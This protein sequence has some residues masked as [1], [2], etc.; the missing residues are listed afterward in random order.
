M[1]HGALHGCWRYT[2]HT[3][4]HDI[5]LTIHKFSLSVSERVSGEDKR[6]REREG[7]LHNSD[8]F[9]DQVGGR[10]RRYQVRN[11]EFSRGFR[12]SLSLSLSL[13]LDLRLS[14]NDI[15]ME[16]LI[17]CYGCKTAAARRI[18][19]EPLFL[20]RGSPPNSLAHYTQ[21]LLL[22]CLFVVLSYTSSLFVEGLLVKAI[23]CVCVGSHVLA[24]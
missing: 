14:V 8:W 24:Q 20:V 2:Y 5:H 3:I 1:Q 17:T 15:I 7:C 4:F 19:G 23:S 13:P 12:Y 21:F 6:E 11:F 22:C 16:M 10:G 18:I 9:L